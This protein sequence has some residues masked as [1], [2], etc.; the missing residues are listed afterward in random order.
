MSIKDIVQRSDT[1]PGRAFDYAIIFLIIF[2][3]ITFPI[4]TLPD[5]SPSVKRALGISEVVVTVLFTIEYCLRILTAPKKF[6]YIFSF[7]GIIDLIAILPFYLSLGVDLRSVR[8]FRL[9]R[10]L[11][12]AKIVQY[13][14]VMAR[15]GK[16]IALSKGEFLVFFFTM[17]ILLYISAVGIYYFEH[18]AQPEIFRSVFHSLWWAVTTLTTVGYGDAY[19]VTI[20]GKLFTFCILMCGMGIVAVPAGLIAAAL[21]KVR[22]DEDR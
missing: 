10:V 18:N 9:L 19:P 22:Q 6:G 14:A 20:G 1:A 21:S 12:L 11:R 15:F 3:L 17:V 8:V 7:Y 5:L 16:A 13:S 2:S 4:D